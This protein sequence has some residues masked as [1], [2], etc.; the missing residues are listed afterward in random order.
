MKIKREKRKEKKKDP[1]G[2]FWN[3]PIYP[4]LSTWISKH[5]DGALPP[6]DL[7]LISEKSIWKN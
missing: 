2:G 5:L 3:N 1:V 4:L 7:Y 6:V